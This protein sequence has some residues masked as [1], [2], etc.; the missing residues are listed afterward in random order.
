MNREKLPMILMLVAGAITCIINLIQNY[1][2]L[3]SLVSLFIVLVLFFFLGSIMKW[4]L[5]SFDRENEKR[6]QEAGEVMEKET[7]EAQEQGDKA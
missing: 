2:I 4:T 6:N 5:N 3:R 1:S 7:E